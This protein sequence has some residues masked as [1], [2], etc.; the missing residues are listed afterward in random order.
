MNTYI[1]TAQVDIEVEAESEK[2]AISEAEMLVGFEVVS[3]KALSIFCCD[4][5]E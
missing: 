3:F 1:V 5:E 4:D 2:D